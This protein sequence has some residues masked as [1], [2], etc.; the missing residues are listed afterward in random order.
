MFTVT[1]LLDGIFEIPAATLLYVGDEAEGARLREAK[2]GAG[3]L[4]PVNAYLLRRDDEVI[5]IDAGTGTVWG[6]GLGHA[7][8]ALAAEGI[9]PE[10]VDR[11]M[12]THLHGDHAFGLFDGDAPYFPRAR[13]SVPAADLAFFTDAAALAATREERRSPFTIA[14]TMLRLYAGRI[15]AFEGTEVLP[16]IAALA[17]PG[18]SPGHTGY[19][20][21]TPD[22]QLLLWGDA[23]HMADVQPRDPRVALT[24]DHDSD[25]ALRSRRFVLA[26]AAREGLRVGGGHIDGYFRVTPDGEGFRL[27]R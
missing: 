1:R 14:E 24:Y 9:A 19:V 12:L 3:T 2:A 26:H 20:L 21:D 6:P 22:G 11:V 15:D 4:V 17:L 18:H 16:G 5:L 8:D 10:R 27:E 7:R 23:L 25:L 13:V